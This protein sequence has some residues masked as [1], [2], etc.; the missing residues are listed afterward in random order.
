MCK[1]CARLVPVDFKSS[2]FICVQRQT[3]SIVARLFFCWEVT[4]ENSVVVTLRCLTESGFQSNFT[5]KIKIT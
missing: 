4:C 5:A 1:I 3:P 2:Y